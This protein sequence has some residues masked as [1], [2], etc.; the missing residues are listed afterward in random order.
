VA[1]IGKNTRVT[2]ACKAQTT[3]IGVEILSVTLPFISGRGNNLLDQITVG[4]AAKPI[5]ALKWRASI[6]STRAQDQL[7]QN[8]VSGA[9]TLSMA[10]HFRHG[11]LRPEEKRFI[12]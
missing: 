8:F 12:G 5:A 4:F 3:G 1:L 6:R 2:L 7:G 10:T 11:R 9:T